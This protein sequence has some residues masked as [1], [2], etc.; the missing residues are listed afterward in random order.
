MVLS[1]FHCTRHGSL[2]GSTYAESCQ[3]C[4]KYMQPGYDNL[5][6]PRIDAWQVDLRHEVYCRW[7]VRVIVATVDV[8]AIDSVLMC[9]LTILQVSIGCRGG[10]EETIR[11][12]AQGWF[13][14]NSTSTGHHHRRAHRSMPLW[15]HINGCAF[16]ISSMFVRTS[17]EAFLALFELL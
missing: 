5:P 2:D 7:Y 14:S 1:R 13:H 4:R 16:L 10:T 12:E 9:A 6:I 15:N 11:E 8:Q 17:A 3:N